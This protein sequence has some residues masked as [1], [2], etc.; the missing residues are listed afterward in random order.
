VSV[1]FFHFLANLLDF[2][3][4][5]DVCSTRA[6][7][8]WQQQFVDFTEAIPLCDNINLYVFRSDTT[9]IK[10]TNRIAI[11][12][13]LKVR[14]Y[15]FRPRCDLNQIVIHFIHQYACLTVDCITH[16]T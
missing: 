16:I 10:Y 2:S 14:G 3:D 8:S 6:I 9:I 11:K 5:N 13:K 1:L 15:M 7:L 12:L 4:P